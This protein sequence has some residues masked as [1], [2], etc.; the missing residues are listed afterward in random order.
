MNFGGHLLS[1]TNTCVIKL[2][3]LNWQVI[4]TIYN[5]SIFSNF[6]QVSLK[7]KMDLQITD[8]YVFIFELKKYQIIL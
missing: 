3:L 1:F 2:Y 7:K 5:K 4:T 8:H 6:N